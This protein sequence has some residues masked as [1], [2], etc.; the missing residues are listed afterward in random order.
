MRTIHFALIALLMSGGTAVAATSTASTGTAAG[1]NGAMHGTAGGS[2]AAAINRT[3]GNAVAPTGTHGRFTTEA[4]AAQS[5]G[6]SNV[7]W[8][9]T[10]SRAYHLS[11]DKYFGHTKHGSW[12]CMG[13]AKAEG[14]HQAGMTSASN[15]TAKRS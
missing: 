5:C 12:M 15:R 3:D 8:A 9:N 1:T 11:G 14:F 4:D 2:G 6:G 13:T 7:V 10:R